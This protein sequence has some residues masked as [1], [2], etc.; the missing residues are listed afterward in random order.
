[1]ITT[2]QYGR[3]RLKDSFWSFF[4]ITVYLLP[5]NCVFSQERNVKYLGIENGLSNNAVTSICQDSKGFMWFGTYDGLNRYDGYNFITF[6]HVIGDSSSLCDN[7]INCITADST[8]NLWIGSRNGVSVYNEATQSFS[9]V[10]YGNPDKRVRNKIIGNINFIK[11][12]GSSLL[13]GETD[14]NIFV[15]R[16]GSSVGQQLLIRTGNVTKRVYE[17]MALTWDEARKVAWVFI[18]NEGLGQYDGKT[19][20]IRFVNTDIKSGNAL[21]LDKHGNIW[22]G[23]DNGLFYYNVTSHKYASIHFLSS[24]KVVSLCLDKLNWLWV[25]SDGKGVFVVDST[26]RDIVRQ[27]KTSSNAVY[28]IYDDKEGRKWIGTLRG[29]IDIIERNPSPFKKIEDATEPGTEG[30]KNFIMSFGE[31][32]DHNVWI[33]TDGGGLRY[34][35]RSKDSYSEYIAN[36]A[37]K[38]ALSSNFIT[39]IITDNEGRTWFSTWF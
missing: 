23:N 31:S 22:L 30:V 11:L 27:F 26:S 15:F 19:N 38:T 34:W 2:A 36:P 9:T 18:Q 32:S 12:C 37:S 24:A 20:E 29:G 25:A 21:Q 4:L 13:V 35:N 33:G 28:A 6:R 10:Y 5:V 8:H 17:P 39:S 16:N 7:S 1:M 14:N 3:K